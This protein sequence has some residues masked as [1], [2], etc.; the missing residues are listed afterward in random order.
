MNPRT[1]MVVSFFVLFLFEVGH[2]GAAPLPQDDQ[3]LIKEAGGGHTPWHQ[4]QGYWPLDN[5]DTV[6]MWMP[7]VDIS[8]D[9]GSMTFADG[10]H[11]GG[12]IAAGAISDDSHAAISSLLERD[13][14]ETT[15]Y[16]AL[17]AGDATFHAGWTLHS[18]GPN[19]SNVERAVMTIIYVAD[20]THITQPTDQQRLDMGWLGGAR[21]GD[22]VDSEM[23]PLVWSTQQNA[24]SASASA[25]R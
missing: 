18:A 23:N 11:L 15:T 4:D 6:T 1:A 5:T 12:D 9:V 16:G 13:D 25:V 20:G 19:K 22:L 8:D 2:T 24:S 21:P 3:A 17:E 10:S 7:L 14:T